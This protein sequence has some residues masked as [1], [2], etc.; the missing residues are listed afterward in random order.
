MD[1]K[2]VL[3]LVRYHWLVIVV[4]AVLGTV[5]GG[6][7]SVVAEREYT[8]RSEVFVTV[9]GGTTTGEVAQSTNYS[10]QQARNFSAVATREIVLEDVI[11]S[12][13]LEMT[14]SELRR[15]VT[16]SVPL[17][18]TVIA[19]SVTDGSAERAAEIANAIAT[20]LAE[21]V[22]ELTPNVDDTSPVRLQIIE[23]AR[24]PAAPS[25]PDT[26]LYVFM[27]LLA[28]LV[29]ASIVVVLRGII[30]ARVRTPEQITELIGATV[31]GSISKS[32]A[33]IQHPMALTSDTQVLRA[34]EYRQ[35]RANLRFLQVGEDHKVFV[36]TSSIPSEG[37]SS[38]AANL[39]A[40]LA[41]SGQSVC[42]IEADLRRPSLA[43]ILDLPEG[44]GV[45]SVLMG[46]VT[47]D[48][49]LLDWGSDGMKVLL[50]G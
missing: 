29:V 46:E 38:T 23:A 31:I 8:A 35:L 36:V 45:T 42:L 4:C 32:R 16:T 50:A 15:T 6:A 19:I 14:L 47:L 13:D 21:V 37:K 2:S 11:E 33:A 10:Q 22:P 28:G 43:D 41:A 5:I 7:L 12:L 24:P 39:A 18:T 26:K 9:T 48:E 40:A 20:R 27:G 1:S 17:N 49:A 30:H 34:E 44:V 3:R 25:A